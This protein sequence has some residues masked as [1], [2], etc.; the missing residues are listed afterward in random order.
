MKTKK[1]LSYTHIILL[2]LKQ[3]YIKSLKFK[4]K[5]LF[6]KI[7]TNSTWSL[8]FDKSVFPDEKYFKVS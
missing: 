2:Q 1:K 3:K 7:I 6:F 8:V 5:T 4:K